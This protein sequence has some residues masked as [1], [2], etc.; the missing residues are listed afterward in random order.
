[1]NEKEKELTGAPD[2]P[3]YV[4]G[5]EREYFLIGMTVAAFPASI[6]FA[7]FEFTLFAAAFMGVAVV[8]ACVAD[9]ACW[10]RKLDTACIDGTYD[11]YKERVNEDG[12]DR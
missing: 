3:T 11:E 4:Y 6:A 2:E 7:Y 1:M 8:T 9:N 5:E 10:R 12:E